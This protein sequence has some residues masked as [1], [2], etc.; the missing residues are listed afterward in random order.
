[1]KKSNHLNQLK[2]TTNHLKKK[3]MKKKWLQR[4]LELKKRELRFTPLKKL[5]AINPPPRKGRHGDQLGCVK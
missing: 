4:K 2:K 5:K 1:M 3:E